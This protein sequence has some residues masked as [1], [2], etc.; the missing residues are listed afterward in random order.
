MKASLLSS[1][2]VP[3]LLFF[4]STFFPNTLNS[5]EYLDYIGAGH[6]N[7]I[8]I[9]SSSNASGSDSTSTVNGHGVMVDT[10]GAS[11]FLAQATLGA[12]YAEIHRTADMGVSAWID[13]QFAMPIDSLQTMH[14]S[15]K[16]I[17]ILG[18]LF[19]LMSSKFYSILKLSIFWD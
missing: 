5:Q 7:G 11:R 10:F 13:E 14:D 3:I 6:N 19:L 17:F 2:F 8:T 15:L 12:N 9:T 1:K 4:S 16:Q 18:C